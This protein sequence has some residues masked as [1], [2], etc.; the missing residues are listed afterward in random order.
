MSDDAYTRLDTIAPEL[1][2]ASVPLTGVAT[3]G[4]PQAGHLPRLADAG[5]RRV[6]DLRGADEERGFDEADAVRGAGMEYLHLPVKGTPDDALFRRF[7]EEMRNTG[8]GPTLVHCGSASRVGGMM[9]PYLVLDRG[10]DRDAAVQKAREIGLRS[11]PLER[12]ALDY[13]ERAQQGG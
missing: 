13:V 8:A 9:L 7:R 1:P 4:Q 5:Y 2:N 10:M 6:I 11:E 12:A 3:A